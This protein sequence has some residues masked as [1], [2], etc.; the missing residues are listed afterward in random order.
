MEM[1]DRYLRVPPP[2]DGSRHVHSPEHWTSTEKL[3]SVPNTSVLRLGGVGSSFHAVQLAPCRWGA[4]PVF[5]FQAL[6][7]RLYAN[8]SGRLQHP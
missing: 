1:P 5:S 8:G 4:E 6:I 3:L 2:G 7:Q